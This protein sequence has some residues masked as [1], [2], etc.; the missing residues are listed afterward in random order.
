V[1]NC[2]CPYH[3]D[4]PRNIV[5]HTPCHSQSHTQRDHEPALLFFMPC[6][7]LWILVIH[8]SHLLVHHH[9]QCRLCHCNHRDVLTHV[10]TACSSAYL[11]AG[12]SGDGPV[13]MSAS[14]RYH[15]QTRAE[16]PLV[17]SSLGGDRGLHSLSE[18]DELEHLDPASL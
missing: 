16:Q 15:L 12:G 9:S 17:S 13:G 8:N 18:E 11:S 4:H 1:L 3:S 14:M 6:D 10:I 7:H 2:T 5:S